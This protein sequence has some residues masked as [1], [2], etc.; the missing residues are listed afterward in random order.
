MSAQIIVA[1]PD[2]AP[3]AIDALLAAGIR[4]IQ[5]MQ[6]AGGAP[7]A[8]VSKIATW[9]GDPASYII[10]LA[11]L[12]WCV[13]RRTAYRLALIL[14]VSNALNII[15]KNAVQL[16]RPYH[17][18]SG[19]NLIEETGYSFPSGHSQNS[20]AFWLCAISALTGKKK[21]A[22]LLLPLCIGLSRICLG[23][24]YPTDVL[25]G[26]IAGSLIALV[27]LIVLPPLARFI[28]LRAPILKE[29]SVA[30]RMPLILAA[31]AA[32]AF[33]G[34]SGGDTSMGGLLFGMVAARYVL[35][36]KGLA[37][38]ITAQEGSLAVKA[39]RLGLGLV[40]LAGLYLG[41]RQ[42]APGAQSP[43]YTLFRF[44]RYAL[45]GAWVTGGAPALILRCGLS[46]TR[47]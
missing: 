28:L 4:L 22:L 8:T 18:V 47:Q 5:A 9:I 13:N 3:S 44:L 16:P 10:L 6:E 17:Q 35:E 15:I 2:A 20:A 43:H 24:H 7:L 29:E 42:V 40:V 21:Y 37:S 30:Q 14:V 1:A 23:L 41:L 34:F 26:W 46:G 38:K 39:A 36:K 11:A 33:N 32:L 45:V 19:L 12:M 25:A 31:A 27:V